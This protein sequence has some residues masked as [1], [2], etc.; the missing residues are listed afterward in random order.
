[1]ARPGLAQ[2]DPGTPKCEWI[3]PGTD[4]RSMTGPN[5][6]HVCGSEER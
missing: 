5:L 2:E 3:E 1:M 6:N 4:V